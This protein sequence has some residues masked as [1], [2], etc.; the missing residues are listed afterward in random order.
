MLNLAGFSSRR[1][2]DGATAVTG[3]G[4]WDEASRAGGATEK[5]PALRAGAFRAQSGMASRPSDAT[6][7]P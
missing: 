6:R 7:G 3:W 4:S 2:G 5:A 1:V